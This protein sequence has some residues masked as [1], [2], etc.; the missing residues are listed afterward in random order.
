VTG[1]SDGRGGSGA[2][3][4]TNTSCVL[5]GCRNFSPC[6]AAT[7]AC[8]CTFGLTGQYCSVLWSSTNQA[9]FDAWRFTFV[10]LNAV[11]VLVFAAA[12]VE[13]WVRRVRSFPWMNREQVGLSAAFVAVA[14]SMTYHAWDPFRA[15][16]IS[17]GTLTAAQRV[18]S[19]LVANVSLSFTAIAWVVVLV[20]WV[21]VRAPLMGKRAPWEV[22][23][24]RVFVG[25]VL[26]TFVM[27]CVCS[28]LVLVIYSTAEAIYYAYLGVLG[29]FFSL[30]FSSYFYFYFAS[31]YH[32]GR[33]SDLCV[34]DVSAA[35]K[36]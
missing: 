6:N 33:D 25:L 23:L 14:L 2:M 19:P 26:V 20:M 15:V 31:V 17:S 3:N 9:A 1:E 28:G 10:A 8:T 16:S 29:S 22:I 21:H 27:A 32:W 12:V 18:G 4:S 5:V 30:L 36:V 24:L 13:F 11:L 34:A 7:G 35:A